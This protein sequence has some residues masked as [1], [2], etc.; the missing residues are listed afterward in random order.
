MNSIQYYLVDVFTNTKYGGNQLAV[1]VDYEN[2][3]SD[4]EMLA[5]AR[6]L[7]FS[8]ITFIKRNYNDEKFKVRIFTPEYEVPFAGHPSLGTAYVIS[9]YLL[10]HPKKQ[11]SLALNYAD[12]Q[13]QLSDLE[14]LDDCQFKM[15]QAQPIFYKTY[16]HVDIATAL[17][18]DVALFDTTKVI[19][20][21]TTGLP[22]IIAHVKSMEAVDSIIL[23]ANQLEDFLMNKQLHKTNNASGLSTSFFFVTE[24][25]IATES[26]Y[27]ARMF[28]LE[29]GEIMED[30]AT[31]SANG[32]FLAYLL[33]HQSKTIHATVEQG[34]KMGRKSHI[35]LDGNFAQN[36]FEIHVSGQVVEVGSGHWKIP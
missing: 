34:F 25:T 16:T 1:F 27:Y 21:V 17:D 28:C 11:I 22:Y 7:G 3:I 18:I 32:C 13:I 4:K 10:K 15:Q 36:N 19:E 26:S 20:E 24:E 29:Q 33:K 9:K 6:E 23:K 30:A 2:K 14:S 35:Y 5:I 31:G 8:E 12:I